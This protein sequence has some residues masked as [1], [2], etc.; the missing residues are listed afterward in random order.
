MEKGLNDIAQAGGDLLAFGEDILLSP[1]EFFSDLEPG[2]IS[3][4]AIFNLWADSI[5][6][7]GERIDAKHAENVAAGG[8]TGEFIYN[9][10]ATT[11]QAV[12]QAV[13]A[14]LTGGTSLAAQTTAGLQATANAALSPGV[15]STVKNIVGNMARDPQY[16]L[17][18]SQ[19]VGNSYQNAVT[20]LEEKS[21]S[22]V[23]SGRGEAMSQGEIRTKA[24]LYALGANLMIA[25]IERS[26]GLQMLPEELQYGDD[27][28]KLMVNSSVSE[29]KEEVLQG[30]LDRAMQNLMLDKDYKLM[31]FTDKDAVFSLPAAA[32]EFGTG[33][34]V[35]SLLSSGQAAMHG[36]MNPTKYAI[37]VDGD[38]TM[39]PLA[40]QATVES[41]QPLTKR[42]IIDTTQLW[43]QQ[44]NEAAGVHSEEVQMVDVDGNQAADK[45]FVITTETPR[46]IEH[47]K[48]FD[49]Q[50]THSQTL[51]KTRMNALLSDLKA[52][53]IREPIKCVEYEGQLYVVDGHHRLLLAKRLGLTEVPVE[54]VELPYSGYSVVDDLLWFD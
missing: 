49:L 1:I 19:N 36:V 32:E 11:V 23:I 38:V 45:N 53:G 35:G 18:F 21:L 42:D 9:M 7:N 52:N 22:D 44:I 25:A 37:N 29:G 8:K 13:V 50:P 54:I 33:T 20:M 10:G 30:V 14:L 5:R 39:N 51:S 12:P 24:A 28:W 3:D 17:A 4:N 15:V 34:F 27:V 31:S 41:V 26:G 40:A 46:N 2:T 16:W 6:R 48:P 47:R 43:M